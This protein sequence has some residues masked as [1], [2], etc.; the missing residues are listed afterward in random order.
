MH[1]GMKAT[2]ALVIKACL[3]V[4]E[5]RPKFTEVEA[6]PAL[7]PIITVNAVLVAYSRIVGDQK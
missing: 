3:F 7:V 1:E 2:R 4:Q 5:W 6:L